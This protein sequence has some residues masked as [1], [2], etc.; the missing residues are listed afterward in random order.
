MG[1]LTH[2]AS[3]FKGPRITEGI[4]VTQVRLHRPFWPVTFVSGAFALLA[5]VVLAALYFRNGQWQYIAL[6]GNAP[7][8][9]RHQGAG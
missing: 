9:S 6:G 2:H 4:M 1:K 3:R 7:D 8:T 5:L